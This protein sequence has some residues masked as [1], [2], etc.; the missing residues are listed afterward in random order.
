MLEVIYGTETQRRDKY[1]HIVVSAN[2]SNIFKY[3][4]IPIWI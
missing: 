3:I 1:A 4:F 2:I